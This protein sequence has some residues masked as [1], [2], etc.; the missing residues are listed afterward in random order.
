METFIKFCLEEA[1]EADRKLC[2]P[3]YLR[4]N[5]LPGVGD[6]FDKVAYLVCGGVYVRV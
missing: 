4:P 3:M 6:F 1:E 5:S 2:L